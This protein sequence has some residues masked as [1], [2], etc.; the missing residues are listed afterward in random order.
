MRGWLFV[1]LVAFSLPAVAGDAK[2]TVAYKGR[3]AD[4]KYAYL[5]KGPDVVSKQ[6]IRRLIL[7]AKDLSGKIAACKTLS[8]TDS[9]LDEGLSVNLD[10]SGRLNYWMVMNGQKVQ[11]SGTEPVASLAAKI[12][13]AK[14]LAGTLK[15]D[16]TAAGGPKVDVDFDAAMAKEV[17]AP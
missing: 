17:T 8:C 7:S 11:Y 16:K 9:D 1:L 2:G 10:G 14:K 3:T 4:I 6:T 13:D 12:D 15:F 5:V